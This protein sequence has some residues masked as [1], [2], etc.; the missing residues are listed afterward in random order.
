MVNS[1]AVIS[2]SD[3]V[4]R[5]VR[6]VAIRDVGRAMGVGVDI[7]VERNVQVRRLNL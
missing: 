6:V 1:R 3:R 4:L 2:V 5:R 7:K